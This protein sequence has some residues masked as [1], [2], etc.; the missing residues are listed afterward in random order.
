MPPSNHLR[1]SLLRRAR[2]ALT[3]TNPRAHIASA[4]ASSTST[5]RALRNAGFP[6]KPLHSRGKYAIAPCRFYRSNNTKNKST[7]KS[8]NTKKPSEK[9]KERQSFYDVL[10][11][12][13][14]APAAQIRRSYLELA[15]LHHPD[16]VEPGGDPS[17]FADIASAY[18]VL[19]DEDARQRYDNRLENDDGDEEANWSDASSYV[20]NDVADAKVLYSQ[21]VVLFGDGAMPVF[22]PLV[23]RLLIHLG[24]PQMEEQGQPSFKSYQGQVPLVLIAILVAMFIK[25]TYKG[26]VTADMKEDVSEEEI[27]RR[28]WLACKLTACAVGAG[29]LVAQRKKWDLFSADGQRLKK[30]YLELIKEKGGFYDDSMK[31]LRRLDVV[32]RLLPRVTF[33]MVGGTV[34]GSYGLVPVS[35]YLPTSMWQDDRWDTL[36]WNLSKISQGLVATTLMACYVGRRRAI[37]ITE[38]GGWGLAL[39]GLTGRFIGWL[40][41]FC[42]TG[43]SDRRPPEGAAEVVEVVSEGSSATT[44]AVGSSVAKVSEGATSSSSSSVA[45]V[46]GGGGGA[47]FCHKCGVKFTA[48]DSQ[49]CSACGTKRC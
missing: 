41:S 36:Q 40:Y 12:P 14:D 33:V 31:D 30:R 21:A 27:K 26:W 1:V 34:V 16:S 11:V 7:S 20:D 5:F 13:H 8:N 19:K 38:L 32:I 48:A 9:K 2:R 22:H 29:V 24:L 23:A 39:T 3:L 18:K 28:R 45:K 4:A 43:F 46:V 15:R 35:W 44:V 42:L 37:G 25:G 49:F 6:P 47:L 10:G 17:L